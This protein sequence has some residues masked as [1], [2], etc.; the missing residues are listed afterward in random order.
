MFHILENKRETVFMN[1]LNVLAKNTGTYFVKR[2]TDEVG[3]GGINLINPW[4]K[5]NQSFSGDLWVRTTSVYGSD[6]DL[7]F[8]RSW[9]GPIINP[10]VS[11]ERFRRKSLQYEFF[12]EHSIPY[13]PWISLKGNDFSQITRKLAQFGSDLLI[14]PDR[15]Q[16][17]WGIQRM[18]EGQLTEWWKGDDHD[19]LLQ[20]FIQEKK[21]FR[22]FF[23]Q[24]DEPII[25]ERMGDLTANFTQ[26][27]EARLSTL[28]TKAALMLT[29][30]AQKSGALYGAIDCFLI[31]DQLVVLELNTCPGI[32]QLENVSGQNIIRKLLRILSP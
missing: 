3:Y 22:F 11:L 17:G 27:G 26:G 29:D 24:D 20:P 28:P 14:K 18:T 1:K 13:L 7:S 12:K 31:K 9:V 15:G 32:E 2:L 8:C 4:I 25:L 6:E 21:E 23:I 5:T 10:L 16:G 30:L 19:F